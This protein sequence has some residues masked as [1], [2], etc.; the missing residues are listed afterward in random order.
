MLETGKS[1]PDELDEEDMAELL[2]TVAGG[3]PGMPAREIRDMVN[4][5]GREL[6]IEAMASM[7]SG[8][9]MAEVLSEQQVRQVCTAMV[10]QAMQKRPRPGRRR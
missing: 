9:P 3:M 10:E 2:A 1:P 5:L 8:S 4:Q 6:T 7:M